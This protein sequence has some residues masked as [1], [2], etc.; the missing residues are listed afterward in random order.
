MAGVQKSWA[1][2]IGIILLLVGIIGFFSGDAVLEIFPVNLSHN[3]VHLITGAVFLWAGF[4]SAEKAKMAN[5]WLGI[6]YILVAVIGF[7][8]YL[9]FLNV[10]GG[11]DPDNWLHV[12]IGVVSAGIGFLSK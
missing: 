1:I 12:A 9:T 7:L 4:A 3:I 2:I 5:K 8:G 6:I 11:N 10:Q